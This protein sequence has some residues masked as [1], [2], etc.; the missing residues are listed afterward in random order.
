M[1]QVGLFAWHAQVLRECCATYYAQLDN[2][3]ILTSF[4]ISGISCLK[5]IVLFID[6]Y[7]FIYL[8]LFSHGKNNRA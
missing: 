8:T 5:D 2:T 4:E 1:C 7:L 3:V 6:I